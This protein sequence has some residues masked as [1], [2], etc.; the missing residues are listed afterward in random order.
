MRCNKCG[1]EFGTGENCQ[2]CGADK[3]AALGDFPGYSVPGG[4]NHPTIDTSSFTSRIDPLSSII[5]WKCGEVIPA[6]SKYCPVCQVQLFV[7]CPKCGH[8]YSAQYANCN[9]CGSNREEYVKAQELAALARQLEEKKRKE[10]EELRRKQ[11]EDARAQAEK[12]RLASLPRIILF[13]GDIRKYSSGDGVSLRWKTENVEYCELSWYKKRENCW[14]KCLPNHYYG[15]NPFVN[16]SP[17]RNS[18]TFGPDELIDMCP[19][20]GG[21]EHE[22]KL[23]LEAFGKNGEFVDKYLTINVL[24]FWFSPMQVTSIKED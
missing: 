18:H 19:L 9:E 6:D 23:C 24:T 16:L 13:G 1:N 12:T 11:Q 4:Q 21:R 5:C 3:V 20:M 8:R 15:S 10:E 17:N 2:H 7:V 22:I 14:Y